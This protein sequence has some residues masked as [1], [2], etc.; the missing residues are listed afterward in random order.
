MLVF[1]HRMDEV[2]RVARNGS[3][4]LLVLVLAL[5]LLLSAGCS[6]TE[7]ADGVD[8]Q[9]RDGILLWHNLPEREAA[10]LDNA[11]DRY[12][13]A[14]P[15]VDVIVEA[16]GDD[17]ETEFERATR[18]GL[19][20][21]LLLTASTNIPTLANAGALLPLTEW[22][23]LEQL[24]RYL[25]VALQTTRYDGNVYGLPVSLNTLVLYYNRSLVE[26]APVTVD[27]LLQEASSGRRVLMNSQFSDALWSAR[28]FGVDLFDGEGNPQDATAGIANWLTWMEQVRDTPGFITDDNSAA[29]RDRFLEGDIPYYIGH[30]R[31]LNVLAD[32]LGGDLAVAQLPAG[33]A[34]SAGPLLSTS[35]FLV[36]AMSSG[37]Q[38]DRALD[39]ALFLTSSDQQAALMREANIVPA[40][41]RTRISEGLYPEIATVEAQ[42]RTA[43]PWYNNDGITRVLG[44]LA[45]AYNQTMAGAASATEAAAAAQTIL[46]E[47]YGFPRIDVAQTCTEI[48][49]LTILAPNTGNF[50][51]ILLTLADGFGEVCPGI[52]VTV[53]RAPV[54]E[55]QG[56]FE[57]GGEFPAAD[58]VFYRH[59]LLRRALAADAI[60]P[61]TDLLDPTLVQQLRPV[62]VGAMRVDNVLYG[63]PIL[64]DPQTL[65][66]NRALVA[67]AAGT[68]ADLRA[69]SQGGAPVVLDGTFEWAFWGVGAFGGRLFGENGQ[70][71]LEPQALI[72]WLDW[73][74]E[75]QRSFGIRTAT[76]R[77]D[78]E[79]AFLDS[80]SAYLVAPAEQANELLLSVPQSDLNVAMLPEG[81]AGP[82]RPF[83]WIDG[84]L[85]NGELSAQKTSLAARFM[86]YAMS[87]DGQTELLIR[88][89][90]LPS[91]S[92]VLIDNYPNVMRMAEQLQSAQ[93]IQSQPW[94]PT[95]VALGNTA[96][97]K[98]LVDGM[99]PA[100]AVREMYAALAADAARY[101]ITVPEVAPAPSATPDA[102]TPAPASS[103]APAASPGT[104]PDDSQP[105]PPADPE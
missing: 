8:V 47:Q 60:M 65:F 56:L 99:A 12:R 75:S 37:N 72:A 38:I 87:V 98:V 23:T 41:G 29:L 101:G 31:E 52:K 40:N 54:D 22:V 33:P 96:Y 68:L 44:V 86:N 92:A 94:L 78:A 59:E 10:A 20:P 80:A 74:Q 97:R 62:A 21:N 16:Q 85:V 32:A 13:R 3:R 50:A 57:E 24:D 103:P 55:I 90:L 36:N 9:I 39:L 100:D 81:P 105:T 27:Q 11:L 77:T 63:A 91:N 26:R 1:F 48:G 61:L 28:A 51:Q 64:V 83:V 42:A 73:L 35:A 84:L 69:Q 79:A 71:A 53:E 5:M 104:V 6:T 66:L 70:F 67:D 95:V 4:R 45:D 89:L 102:S 17:M 46:V 14:N 88:H 25:S 49:E 7:T 34:G 19:G 2:R 18:S 82:G 43:I 15:G 93:V 76:Q 58:M 30:S